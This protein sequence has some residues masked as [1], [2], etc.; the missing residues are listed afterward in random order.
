MPK[1]RD[2]G[3]NFIP[4]TMR[5]PEIGQGGGYQAG[6]PCPDPSGFHDSA[7]CDITP[8][9]NEKSE[10]PPHC[11]G[12]SGPPKGGG[13]GGKGKDGLTPEDVQQLQQQ[14]QGRIAAR[15]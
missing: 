10:K 8:P 7:Q 15:F 5:P 14:M 11:E 9:C 13:G 12:Q 3:I 1:I 4:A 2:L 6:P